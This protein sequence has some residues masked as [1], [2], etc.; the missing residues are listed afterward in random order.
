[1]EEVSRLF[2][3]N[4]LFF[5]II[6]IIIFNIVLFKERERKTLIIFHL[7]GILNFVFEIFLVFSGISIVFTSDLLMAILILVVVSWF[8]AGL[9]FTITYINVK[10]YFGNSILSRASFITLNL[11]FFIGLPLASINWSINGITIIS[12]CIIEN[13]P[14]RLGSQLVIITIFGTLLFLTGYKKLV[15]L[16]ILLGNILGAILGLRFYLTITHQVSVINILILLINMAT[17]AVTVTISGIFLLVIIGKVDFFVYGDKPP[18]PKY[19]MTIR[20]TITALKVLKSYFGLKTIFSLVHSLMSQQRKGEPWLDLPPP[21]KDKDKNSRALIGDSILIYRALLDRLSKKKA[22]SIIREVILEASIIQLYC[23]VPII[24]KDEILS[25][26]Q[27]ERNRELSEMIEKFPN[28]DWKVL[29]SSENSFGYRIT[30]CRLVELIKSVGHPELSDAFCQGDGVY[31]E[32][33][34]PDFIFKRPSLIGAGDN[35]CDFI[36]ILK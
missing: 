9:F 16:M 31:F 5:Y 7:M 20:I 28:T 26:N 33:H 25:K 23:L 8:D 34:Q 12:K 17:F 18:L 13:I 19:V 2:S 11:L 35:Y 30:R 32:R 27:E 10:K 22:K 4:A 21:Q 29:Q 1:V 36:F 6:L 15:S 3:F 14:L 24:H